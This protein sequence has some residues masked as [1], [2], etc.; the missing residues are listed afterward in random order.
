MTN[1]LF[2][3]DCYFFIGKNGI[4]SLSNSTV[5]ELREAHNIEKMYRAGAFG[6]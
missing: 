1:E 3:P 6:G 4:K 2:R 5:K